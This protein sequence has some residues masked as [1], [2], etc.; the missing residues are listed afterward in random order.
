MLAL[1]MVVSITA[2][3]GC[4]GKKEPPKAAG[5]PPPTV[6]DVIIARETHVSDELEVNGE[7]T[8]NEFVELHP[9]VSGRLVF[10]NVP[11][12]SQV[13][14][15]FVV[16]RIN[17]ADLQA[18]LKRSTVQ[19]ELAKQSEGRLKQL[20]AVNGIN[21]ADYD[22]ALNQVNALQAEIDY[23]QA[24]IEK[25]VV[26][27]PFAGTIG[28]RQV[29]PGAYV[30]PATTIATLQQVQQL[31]V[32]FSVPEE[33]GAIL[34]KGDTVTVV[35]GLEVETPEAAVVSAVEP[36]ASRE[37]RTMKVRAILYNTQARPGAFVKVRLRTATSAK[38][39]LIPTN[40]IIPDAMSKKVVTVKGGKAVFVEVETGVRQE[41][42]VE[43]T[44]GL[45]AGDSVVVDGVLF[46]RPNAPVKVRDVKDLGQ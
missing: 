13:S 28:L 7:V 46:A 25:T 29:S 19:L 23:S 42:F 26:R 4:G 33:F 14:Q 24:L 44:K 5:G 1:W 38:S 39:I 2:L 37:T 45:Q 36:Q 35:S 31:K 34:K 18:Q 41:R 12:G 9:E 20:L 40:A 30:T 10:L 27:A 15:G 8:A 32:D 11:E 22:A 16:A 3:A 21:Q 6:V 43:V 17:D